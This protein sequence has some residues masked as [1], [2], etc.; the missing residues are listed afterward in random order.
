[1]AVAQDLTGQRFGFLTVTGRTE[2]DEKGRWRWICRCDC[3]AETAVLTSNLRRSDR[4]SC[5]CRKRND[6]T[7]QKIGKLTVLERSDQYATR[8]QRKRQ[9]WKCLCDCGEVT[10]KAT[11]TLTNPD[12]SMCKACAASYAAGK[13]RENAGYREGTQ[14]SR[15]R[16]IS[17]DSQ[18]L[19]GVRGVYLNTKTGKYRVR[20]KFKGVT[21]NLGT[22]SSLEAAIK[23]R[24]RAEEEIFGKYLDACQENEAENG[25]NQ[26]DFS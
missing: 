22:F 24:A 1:M 12:R 18:N 20:I 9:L 19:S 8:G 14:L 21:Y 23:E 17:P 3:G 4:V 10:Y 25:N 11:D 16:D 26:H 5:G 2:P 7:G 6:L 15:I 13:A